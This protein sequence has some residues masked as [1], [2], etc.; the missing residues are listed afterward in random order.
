[1]SKN[2]EFPV[3]VIALIVLG[4]ILV[5]AYSYYY[6]CYQ[7]SSAIYQQRQRQQ[8]QGGVSQPPVYAGTKPLPIY[9]NSQPASQ[10]VQ[11]Q[12]VPST[13]YAQAVAMPVATGYANPQVKV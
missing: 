4:I 6:F 2:T 9:G 8:Q 3:Y 13:G 12:V 5:L 10:V 11:A 1:V 7:K